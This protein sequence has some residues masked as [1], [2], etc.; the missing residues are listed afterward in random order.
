M[1]DG[2]H[3]KLDQSARTTFDETPTKRRSWESEKNCKND[4]EDV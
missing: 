3:W 1:S 2:W 4:I